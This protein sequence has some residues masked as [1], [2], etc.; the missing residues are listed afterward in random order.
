MLKLILISS[1]S[2]FILF[3]FAAWYDENY[4]H[5]IRL[6]KGETFSVNEKKEI[7][8]FLDEMYKKYNKN[9]LEE[10]MCT[11]LSK[12]LG[13]EYMRLLKYHNRNFYDKNGLKTTYGEGYWWRLSDY[14]SRMKA[15]KLLIEAVLND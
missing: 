9:H 6:R 2:L 11:L 14:R 15:T 1:I 7:L 5:G 10:G 13:S 8:A 4:Y 3:L 12:N